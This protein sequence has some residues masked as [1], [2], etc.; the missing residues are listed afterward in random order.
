VFVFHN[1]VGSRFESRPGYRLSR[2]KDFLSFFRYIWVLR[3]LVTY[4]GIVQNESIIRQQ[5]K[6]TVK[7]KA[8]NECRIF[9]LRRSEHR[10]KSEPA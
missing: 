1:L 8:L 2:L 10:C 4:Q 3:S 7:K 5:L 6:H 9:K